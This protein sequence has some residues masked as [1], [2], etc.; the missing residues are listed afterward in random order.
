MNHD[1][2]IWTNFELLA[3]ESRDLSQAKK[4]ISV[5]KAEQIHKMTPILTLN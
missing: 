3:D 5:V 1:H 4:K 2:S